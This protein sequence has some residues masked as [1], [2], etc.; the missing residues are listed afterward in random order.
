LFARSLPSPKT[1]L[2][3]WQ[4]YVSY[5]V[6]D[7]GTAGAKFRDSGRIIGDGDYPPSLDADFIANQN[8]GTGPFPS[9]V[10]GNGDHIFA[11]RIDV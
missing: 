7:Y 1:R 11:S 9:P 2:E 10:A 3:D 5:S 6:T 8:F 4:L